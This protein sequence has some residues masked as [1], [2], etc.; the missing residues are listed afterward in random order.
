MMYGRNYFI[1]AT[2]YHLAKFITREMGVQ[3]SYCIGAQVSQED[4]VWEGEEEG[5][6]DFPGIVQTAWS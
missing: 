2:D 6:G 4:I 3:T 5:R 1:Q